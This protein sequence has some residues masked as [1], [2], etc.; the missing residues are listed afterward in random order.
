MTV[1]SYA[2]CKEDIMLLRAL[3]TVPSEVGFYI[4]VGAYDP[5]YDSVTKLF[6]DHGWRG[7]NI[8]P[9]PQGFARFSEQ[10]PRDI[11]LQ[12]AASN[13]SGT[14]EFH[15]I[16]GE[17]LGTVVKS[18]ADRHEAAGFERRTYTVATKTLTEI[19]ER[20]APNEIHFLRSTWKDTKIKS[21]KAWTSTAS[22][23]GS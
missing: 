3:K 15:E 9:W 1:V 16:V 8:E 7:I 14:T 17:Q 18:I 10:R 5:E 11:N 21:F 4:D 20:Y 22:D 23:P 6:Y 12:L 13:T 19:C 2:Q